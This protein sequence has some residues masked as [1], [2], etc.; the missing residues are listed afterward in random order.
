MTVFSKHKV[1]GYSDPEGR[2]SIVRMVNGV[3]RVEL[4]SDFDTARRRLGQVAREQRRKNS[5]RRKSLGQR[6]K[7]SEQRYSPSQRRRLEEM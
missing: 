4:Y 5:E 3:P 7:P 1:N 6:R 2:W